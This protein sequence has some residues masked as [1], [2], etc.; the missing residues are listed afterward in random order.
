MNRDSGVGSDIGSLPI[1]DDDLFDGQ[2]YELKSKSVIPTVVLD[3]SFATADA[4]ASL[5]AAGGH[6]K[7]LF[8]ESDPNL[9]FVSQR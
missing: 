5:G 4:F 6:S 7:I 9:S 1:T 2:F 8:P 3:E